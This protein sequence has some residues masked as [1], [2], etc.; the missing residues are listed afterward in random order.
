LAERNLDAAERFWIA[1]EATFHE[2]ARQPLGEWLDFPEAELQHL[3]LWHVN[4][5]PHHLVFY[6][7]A[8][9]VI[10]IVRVIHA[11]R[12]WLGMLRSSVGLN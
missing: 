6:K 1:A 9:H 10:D 3:R 7:D 5:F 2:L 12:D 4:G 8:N 11:A